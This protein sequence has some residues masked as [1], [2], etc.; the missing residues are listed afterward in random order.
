MPCAGTNFIEVNS[1]LIANNTGGRFLRS[2]ALTARKPVQTDARCAAQSRHRVDRR[3]S[4]AA[5]VTPQL[6]DTHAGCARSSGA[7][8]KPSKYNAQSVAERRPKRSRLVRNVGRLWRISAF[9]HH[10]R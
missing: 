9:S 6:I 2:K 7:I 3:Y 1:D 8:R 5:E 4:V 10:G